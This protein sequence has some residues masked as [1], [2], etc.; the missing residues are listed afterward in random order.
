MRIAAVRRHI[1]VVDHEVIGG[2]SALFVKFTIF[3]SFSQKYSW[4]F[5]FDTV[6]VM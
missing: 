6:F 3:S 1:S 2:I 5:R 4:S